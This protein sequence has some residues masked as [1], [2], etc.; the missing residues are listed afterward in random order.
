MK[1]LNKMKSFF[2]KSNSQNNIL[3]PVCFEIQNK[4]NSMDLNQARI[5]SLSYIKDYNIIFCAKKGV[6]VSPKNLERET[7]NSLVDSFV[8]S[9]KKSID[10]VFKPLD[11]TIYAAFKVYDYLKNTQIVLQTSSEFSSDLTDFQSYGKRQT[12]GFD[13]V[14]AFPQTSEFYSLDFNS[15]SGVDK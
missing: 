1:L 15:Y 8:E 5:A 6:I 7:Q 14:S 13:Q 2:Y 11:Q 9:I 3:N 10:T 4:L 12:V